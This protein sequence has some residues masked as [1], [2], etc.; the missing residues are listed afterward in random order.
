[1]EATI[2]CPIAAPTLP[3]IIKINTKSNKKNIENINMVNFEC[4]KYIVILNLPVPS[5]I[6][7]TIDNAFPCIDC[8]PRSAATAPLIIFA[9]P[10][11]TIP[12]ANITI[13]IVIVVCEIN[14]NKDKH[15]I[16]A[17][18]IGNKINVR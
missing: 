17:N 16:A 15:K 11:N 9:G 12:V 8:V 6:P 14:T 7:A 4:Y 3:K 2:D 1:M 5:T 13:L 10:P 18:N